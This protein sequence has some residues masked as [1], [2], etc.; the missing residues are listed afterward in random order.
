MHKISIHPLTYIILLSLLLCGYFN[1]FLIISFILLFHHLGHIL[2][3][4]IFKIK[5]YKIDILP[6]GSI[7]NTKINYNLNSNILL[8]LSLAGIIMQLLLYPI[9]PKLF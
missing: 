6:F 7:I 1:Y 4:L 5:I 8:L 9:F 2:V 3:M